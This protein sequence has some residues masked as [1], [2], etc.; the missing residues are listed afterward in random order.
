MQVLDQKRIKKIQLW[1]IICE[2]DPTLLKSHLD[3]GWIYYLPCGGWALRPYNIF[4]PT[5]H[6]GLYL[7]CPCVTTSLPMSTSKSWGKPTRTM[8]PWRQGFRHPTRN[9]CMGWFP[10]SLPSIQ[11]SH[12]CWARWSYY[13]P[14]FL[15]TFFKW[16][17]SLSRLLKSAWKCFRILTE[18][19]QFTPLIQN[20]ANDSCFWHTCVFKG[21][22]YHNF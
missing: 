17:F 4:I 8:I 21:V 10:K 14:L 9:K 6:L 16:K 11:S 13:G 7:Q 19:L 15:Y 20:I 22:Y 3:E 2:F 1:A 18:D 12:L 5:L